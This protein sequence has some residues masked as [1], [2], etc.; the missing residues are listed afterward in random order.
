MREE[1][2][3]SITDRLYSKSLN[4]INEM[5]KVSYKGVLREEEEGPIEGTMD[6]PT[7]DPT[8]EK[9]FWHSS[10]EVGEDVVTLKTLGVGRNKPVSVYINDSRWELFPGPKTAEKEAKTFIKSK[11]FES[12]KE[13]R[14]ML[15]KE[16]EEA[17]AETPE[18]Q[19]EPVNTEEK[20]EAAMESLIKGSKHIIF[21]DGNSMKVDPAS[22]KAVVAMYERLNKNNKTIMEKMVNKNKTEFYKALEFSIAN[23]IG[24]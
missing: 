24:V 13:K 22:S 1:L 15:K 20:P 6:D 11:Q 23:L 5:R 2:K 12:W 14:G 9:E 19:E 17:P 18:T 10:F 7:L 16:E 8:F 4:R 21:E 3:K